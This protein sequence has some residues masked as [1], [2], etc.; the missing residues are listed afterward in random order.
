MHSFWVMAPD[1]MQWAAFHK[2]GGTDARTVLSTELLDV[3]SYTGGHS[4]ISDG[5]REQ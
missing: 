5:T 4:S 3:E 2:Y 1:T